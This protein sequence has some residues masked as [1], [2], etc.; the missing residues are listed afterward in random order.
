MAAITR[1]NMLSGLKV[2]QAMRRNPLRL[3]QGQSL[4]LAISSLIKYKANA[5]LIQDQAR[6]NDLGLISKT[7]LMALYYAGLPLQ[8]T[9]DQV[10][11]AP[12]LTC[13]QEDTLETALSLMLERGVKRVYAQ[14]GEEEQIIGVLSYADIVGLLY[15]VCCRCKKS[16]SRSGKRPDL[17]QN[18]LV[19]DIMQQEVVSCSPE[20]SISQALGILSLQP[21]SALLVQDSQGGLPGVLSK[22]DLILAYRH[23]LPLETSVQEISSAPALS[24]SRQETLVQ[25]LQRMILA[26]VHRLFVHGSEPWQILGVLSLTDAARA[27]SGSCR[28]CTASRLQ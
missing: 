19:Q 20:D 17:D 5:A 28:A 9:L 11:V 14:A 27:R 1:Q 15:R 25:A 24:C 4:D 2:R 26:D 12:I 7:D 22:T 6:E 8:T 10:L 16:L 18:L 3:E 21:F 13:S 23:S